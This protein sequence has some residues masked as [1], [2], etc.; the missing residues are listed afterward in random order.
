[1]GKVT[2]IRT[3]LA[4]VSCHNWFIHQLDINNAFL[5]GDLHEDVYMV[6]PP[7]F[8]TPHSN[9]VCKLQ[10]SLYG[11]KQASK[12][13]NHKLTSTLLSYGFVTS[14]SDPSLFILITPIAFT[15]LLVYDD[16]LLAGTSLE[17]IS[18]INSYLHKAFQIK[19][20]GPLKYFLGLEVARSHQGIDVSQRKYIFGASSRVWF[21][22]L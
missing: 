11:P 8:S 12:Q 13:L 16:V 20:I 1:M 9:L 15:V 2:T 10:K 18:Y 14:I 17:V 6:L 4:F 3:V 5:H 19:D 21:S 7:G 22:R